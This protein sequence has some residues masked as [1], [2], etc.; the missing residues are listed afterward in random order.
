[1]GWL[2]GEGLRPWSLLLS[3]SQDRRDDKD[4][5]PISP[6]RVRVL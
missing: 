6:C 2:S 1:M 5:A 4:A 3:K